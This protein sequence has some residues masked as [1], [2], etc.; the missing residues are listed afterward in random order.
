MA[1]GE[2]GRGVFEG[3]E[4]EGVALVGEGGGEEGS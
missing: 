3:G 2:E 1:R 4:A